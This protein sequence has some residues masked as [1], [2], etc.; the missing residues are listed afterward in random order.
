MISEIPLFLRISLMIWRIVVQKASTSR[1]HG[2]PIK[3]PLNPLLKHS[4]RQNGVGR[5]RPI[6]FLS[7]GVR[8][9][10]AHDR[11]IRPRVF[12]TGHPK[13]R[14]LIFFFCERIVLSPLTLLTQM[15]A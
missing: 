1:Q 10:Y 14:F 12:L 2:G 9:A 13:V 11:T 6:G 7:T 3:G 15:G 8:V 5:F 4:Y